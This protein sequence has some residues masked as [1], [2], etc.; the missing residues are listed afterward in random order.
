MSV[1][2]ILNQFSQCFS[3]TELYIDEDKK[4]FKDLKFNRFSIFSLPFLMLSRVA[5][6]AMALVCS[7]Y[8]T[9]LCTY[10]ICVC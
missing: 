4:T 8:L 10:T 6:A 3:L 7:S 1:V 2:I 9:Y 5:R